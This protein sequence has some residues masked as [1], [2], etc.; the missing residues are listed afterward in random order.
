M[1]LFRLR[2]RAHRLLAVTLDAIAAP[3]A[4]A[5]LEKSSGVHALRDLAAARDK[6]SILK[7]D[8]SGL[9]CEIIY[10]GKAPV[11]PRNLAAVVGRQEAHL[12]GAWAAYERGVVDDWVAFLREDW[13]SAVRHDRFQ[14]LH[15]A[16]AK[17]IREDEFGRDLIQQLV[18]EADAGRDAEA[19]RQLRE[20]AVGVGGGNLPEKTRK[21]LEGAVLGYLRKNRGLLPRFS[22][23]ERE[24]AA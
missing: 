7:V 17:M 21:L 24:A 12:N 1:L 10:L 6:Y 5:L 23:A 20:K 2:E 22:L 4:Q 13:C 16:L 14:G 11:E 18:G 19:I 9:L 8:G 3:Q 15:D